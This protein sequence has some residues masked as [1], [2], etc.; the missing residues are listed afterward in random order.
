MSQ[1][2]STP[3]AMPA[4]IA[5]DFEQFFKSFKVNDA[6]IY[7]D[8]I[9]RIVVGKPVLRIEFNHVGEW[10]MLREQ[11]GKAHA[12]LDMH[13]LN[14]PEEALEELA[15]AFESICK[16]IHHDYAMEHKDG[17]KVEVVGLDPIW[18][19]TK[20]DIGHFV[21]LQGKV[22]S[23]GV[24]HQIK[25][26]NQFKCPSCNQLYYG[27]GKL[28]P[29]CKKCDERCFDHDDPSNIE[30][31]RFME[32]M[33]FDETSKKNIL[34][35]DAIVRIE[36]RGDLAHENFEFGDLLKVT[37]IVKI[38]KAIRLQ[39]MKD[40]ETYFTY[41]R[42]NAIERVVEKAFN[43]ELTEAD[44]QECRKWAEENK[45]REELCR[46]FCPQI[47]G[48]DVIK[49]AILL[50]IIGAD[51]DNE[52]IRPDTHILVIADPSTGK[53][54]LGREA[55][56]I[57]G[58]IY[59]DSITLSKVGIGAGIDE[60]RFGQK[61]VRAGIGILANG[62]LKV[63]DEIDKVEHRKILDPL[64]TILESGMVTLRKSIIRDFI[65]K[66][67]WFCTGNPVFGVYDPYKNITE[68]V[69][70]PIPLLTRFDL[71]FVM[72]DVPDKEKDGL[73]VD[74]IHK[75]WQKQV[76]AP[77]DKQF[78]I[79][80]LRCA[81]EITNIELTP[82]VLTNLKAFYQDLRAV[83]SE[84]LIKVGTRQYEGLLRLSI[85]NCK[86]HLRSKLEDE[87]ADHAIALYNEMLK[88][89][90]VDVNTG[91][92]DVGVLY[93]KPQSEV[94]KNKM[95]FDVFKQLGGGRGEH[96]SL[97]E[98]TLIEE[99]VKTQKWTDEQDARKTLDRMK[100]EGQIYE[101]RPGFWSKA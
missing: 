42:V 73:K 25:R 89:I 20:S 14:Q 64:Y 66:G 97:A 78:L 28:P 19:V 21:C 7:F 36:L 55:A 72:R 35:E 17:F 84:S 59:Q 26:K 93:G 58:G 37:G 4:A 51:I 38:G 13:I 67:S 9:D 86:M 12:R 69:N 22:H 27:F 87:D 15:V 60:D 50:M 10:Q 5:N 88:K 2:K 95:F 80:Y 75:K 45:V 40:V 43:Y 63:L 90:G 34:G 68:N 11:D 33:L 79:K 85:A 1:Q 57:A 31:V 74:N 91:K 70:I 29:I 65:A 8:K 23:M 53:T 101:S 98:K 99:M 44:R 48:E 39:L 82:S 96:D 81:R 76:V 54:D 3:P 62:K 6:R 92:Q 61:V 56:E 41:V 52:K 100:R 71:I 94:S 16:E 49:D 83:E 47:Y 32:L 46:S 77:L 24:V 30:D 18:R